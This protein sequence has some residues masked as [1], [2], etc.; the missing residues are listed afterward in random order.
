MP[1]GPLPV[2]LDVPDEAKSLAFEPTL[3]SRTGPGRG[4]ALFRI[5]RGRNRT[6]AADALAG[7]AAELARSRRYGR[8][9][10]LIGIVAA[11]RPPA[12]AATIH[13]S[14]R[15]I[16]SVWTSSSCVYVLLPE[17]DRDAAE[18]VLARLSEECDHVLAG[19]VTNVAVFPSDALT[20]QT[21]LEV[22]A[23]RMPHATVDP[24]ASFAA[25]AAGLQAVA[26]GASAS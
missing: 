20:G 1:S 16:D 25:A 9:L 2:G 11:G 6:A 12:T 4:R 23:G 14:V 8:P 7:F 15:A 19:A 18:A 5:R 21:M 13:R 26:G 3:V 17:S 24:P 22:A 10:A